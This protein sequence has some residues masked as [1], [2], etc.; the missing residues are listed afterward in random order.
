[1]TELRAQLESA[2]ATHQQAVYPGEL[3]SEVLA[4]EQ[5]THPLVVRFF[6]GVGALAAAAVLTFAMMRIG[7]ISGAEP[8][9]LGRQLADLGDRGRA[10]VMSVSS[11]LPNDWELPGLGLP[12]MSRPSEFPR[13]LRMMSP[14]NRV[15]TPELPDQLAPGQHEKQDAGTER[16]A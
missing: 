2:R 3:A 16:A 8:G 10:L 1:M 4:P 13:H 14:I 15:S 7:G 12:Q 6:Y 9:R 11:R 5:A